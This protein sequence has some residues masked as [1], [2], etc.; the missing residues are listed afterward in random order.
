LNS[1]VKIKIIKRFIKFILEALGIGIAETYPRN[2]LTFS[3]FI[4]IVLCRFY[5]FSLL[6]F[7][8]SLFVVITPLAISRNSA[9][10]GAPVFP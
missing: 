9:K 2:A 5:R 7:G 1:S 6:F 3:P 4:I 10:E 8:F